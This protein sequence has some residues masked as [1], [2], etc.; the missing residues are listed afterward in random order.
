M[1]DGSGGG[2]TSENPR[3]TEMGE[4]ITAHVHAEIERKGDTGTTQESRRGAGWRADALRK[5]RKPLQREKRERWTER[6]REK[7]TVSKPRASHSS[8]S[9]MS[10]VGVWSTDLV[11]F[12]LGFS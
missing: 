8:S 4:A 2:A 6:D 11:V 10:Y 5:A 1:T 12:P 7:A 9:E 3:R